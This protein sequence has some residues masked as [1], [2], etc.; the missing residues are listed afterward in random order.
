MVQSREGF[1]FPVEAREPFGIYWEGIQKN[2]NRHLPTKIGVYRTVDFSHPAGA[3]R[4][5]NFIWADANA[6]SERHAIIRGC[7]DSA[8]LLASNAVVRRDVSRWVRPAAL[9]AIDNY[10]SVG[11]MRDEGNPAMID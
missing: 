5:D 1:R 8:G 6:G 7:D 10:C 2:L 4:G 11:G 9:T 3:D